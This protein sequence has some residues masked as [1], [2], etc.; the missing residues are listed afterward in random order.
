MVVPMSQ[1]GGG[2]PASGSI[3]RPPS[4]ALRR[5]AIAIMCVFLGS[6]G[7][8]WGLL[9]TYFGPDYLADRL[10]WDP[11]SVSAYALTA[12]GGLLWAGSLILMRDTRMPERLV[13]LIMIGL[14]RV[15]RADAAARDPVV[16]PDIGPPNSDDAPSV[17]D[18]ALA[19]R[20][21][22][23]WQAKQRVS[24][25]EKPVYGAIALINLVAGYQEFRAGDDWEVSA[26]LLTTLLISTGVAAVLAAC[27]FV[28]DRRLDAIWRRY[29]MATMTAA[30]NDTRIVKRREILERWRNR[31]CYIFVASVVFVG[32][33]HWV[34]RF[35]ISLI[36]RSN[37]VNFLVIG[38]PFGILFLS[39]PTAFFLQWRILKV[40]KRIDLERRRHL[41]SR[42][43]PLIHVSPRSGATPVGCGFASEATGED[44][45]PISTPAGLGSEMCPMI[46]SGK[47]QLVPGL[48]PQ[49]A[50]ATCR[51]SAAETL[52]LSS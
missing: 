7:F 40:D 49:L 18:P 28:L 42:F 21:A 19:P 41:R 25:L 17:D 37:I 50:V 30:G 1:P 46:R 52:S 9:L 44:S 34:E 2:E 23:L 36:G 32:V 5:T 31:Y 27:H 14:V 20:A 4:R 45:F 22:R 29:L 13:R 3:G 33:A 47:R 38:L 39:F 51:R 35:I 16:V 26:S 24:Y 15:R 8:V 12:V 43:G 10:G 6:A 48:L 11:R